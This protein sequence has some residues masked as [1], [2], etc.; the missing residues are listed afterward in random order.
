MSCPVCGPASPRVICVHNY[1]GKPLASSPSAPDTRSGD[2]Q[3]SA[4]A[5]TETV[6]DASPAAGGGDGDGYGQHLLDELRAENERL[7]GVI[8]RQAARLAAVPAVLHQ[9]QYGEA[10]EGDLDDIAWCARALRGGVIEIPI[11]DDPAY[12]VAS[13][14]RL[15]GDAHGRGK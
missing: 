11:P 10:S 9:L 7:R 6:G 15:D 1:P 5:S 8:A 3:A 13:P 14:A 4:V 12:S 2:A